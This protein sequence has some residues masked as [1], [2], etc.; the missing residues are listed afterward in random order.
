MTEFETLAHGLVKMATK[1]RAEVDTLQ[2]QV[3]TLTTHL[4]EMTSQR[5]IEQKRE[6]QKEGKGV[7]EA[8]ANGS[9][10]GHQIKWI[11][12]QKS[13]HHRDRD[14]GRNALRTSIQPSRGAQRN[15]TGQDSRSETAERLLHR[16]HFSTG[17]FR[18][19]C[20]RAGGATQSGKAHRAPGERNSS[21]AQRIQLPAIGGVRG[22]ERSRGHHGRV[23]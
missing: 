15:P 12:D 22:V 19:R 23:P 7:R 6:H 16:A 11:F 9:E 20:K 21:G 18:G 14:P 8:F 2:S 17:M 13:G 1:L 10:H 5:E 3:P 4:Q